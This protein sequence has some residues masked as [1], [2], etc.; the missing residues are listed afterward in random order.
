MLW[1]GNQI[2]AR[3]ETAIY[4]EYEDTLETSITYVANGENVQ[5]LPAK[6]NFT[7]SG[8]ATISS[9]IPVRLGFEFLG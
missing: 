1:Q 4:S 3:E 6:T 2:I 9:A 8:I 5:N 7:D